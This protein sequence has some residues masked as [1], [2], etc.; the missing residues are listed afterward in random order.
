MR[1]RFLGEL[2]V[3]DVVTVGNAVAGFLATIVAFQD[4]ALSARLILVAAIADGLDGIIARARGGSAVGGYLDSL[5]DVASF[6]VAPAVFV[7]A[8]T[9]DGGFSTAMGVAAAAIPA[10]YVAAAVVRL[11]FYM[12]HDR[13]KPETAGVQ[14]TLAATILAVMYLAG[15]TAPS[16]LLGATGVLCYLMIASISYPELYARDA[17]VLGGLQAAAIAFPTAFDRVF[18]RVLFAFALGY[19]LLAPFLYWREVE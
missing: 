17:V 10:V 14:T 13:K 9:T 8:V 6:G 1:P 18:P 2:G 11:G 16:I 7:Y 12:Q 15:I 5:S 19:L 4:P 3:A